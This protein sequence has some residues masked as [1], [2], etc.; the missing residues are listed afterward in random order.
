[1]S[2]D[3]LLHFEGS[4]GSTTFTDECGHTVTPGGS[5]QISTGTSVFGTG[6]GYFNG[7]NS[8]LAVTGGTSLQP[9]GAFTVELR[10][11]VTDP[12]PQQC[13]F[14]FWNSGSGNGVRLD[15]YGGD[16]H[17]S[18]ENVTGGLGTTYSSG[19]AISTG[20]FHHV[21]VSKSG[22][23]TKVFYDGNQ[24]TTVTTAVTF[25]T[26]DE[27]S[28]GAVPSGVCFFGGFM[29]FFVLFQAYTLKI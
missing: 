22:N 20:V 9:S 15:V 1:M 2:I 11:K 27:Y 23:T 16:L 7:T 26:Y 24:V 25:S 29:D 6:S 10:F 8:R 19:L 3:L 18:L 21:A 17:M 28:I 12:S 14:D 4:N 5:A 13:L